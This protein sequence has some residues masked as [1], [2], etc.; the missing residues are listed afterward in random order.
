MIQASSAESERYFYF[1]QRCTRQAP[2]RKSQK[3]ADMSLVKSYLDSQGFN[4]NVPNK[5]KPTV[6]RMVWYALHNHKPK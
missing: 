3:I 1:A 6:D 2:G 4:I 5:W